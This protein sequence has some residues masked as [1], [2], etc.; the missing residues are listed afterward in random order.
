MV[1]GFLLRLV[2]LVVT[3]VLFA[4]WCIWADWLVGLN[5]VV[6]AGSFGLLIVFAVRP[7]CCGSLWCDLFWLLLLQRMRYGVVIWV[8]WVLVIIT[9][10]GWI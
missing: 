4:C 6:F 5:S 9:V 1:C 3:R 10:L 2:G 7:E 8:L